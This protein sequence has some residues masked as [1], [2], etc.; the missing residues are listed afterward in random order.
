MEQV[1]TYKGIGPDAYQMQGNLYDLSGD[2][3]SA[4]NSYADGLYYFPN[5]GNLYL[6]LGNLY[7]AG[8]MIM[9]CPITKKE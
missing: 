8:N 3:V 1:M 9:P 4:I 7:L 6:E 2:S 5:A